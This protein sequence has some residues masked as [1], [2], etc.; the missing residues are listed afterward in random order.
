MGAVD[1]EFPR[2]RDTK[3]NVLEEILSVLF[4][5]DIPL[6]TKAIRT[7]L[8]ERHQWVINF[9]TVKKFVNE[10]VDCGKVVY[11]GPIKI[12]GYPV[13]AFTLSE[14]ERDVRRRGCGDNA[15]SDRRPV[16]GRKG[17]DSG[18]TS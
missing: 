4:C 16:H 1:E 9:D 14:G 2:M 18:G 17:R 11:V 13:N 7:L 3:A 15:V 5:S 10:L 6:T 12:D 8:R